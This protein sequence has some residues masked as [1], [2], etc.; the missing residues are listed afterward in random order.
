MK[1]SYPV[2][3]PTT[4]SEN[5]KPA[6]AGMCVHIDVADNGVIVKAFPRQGGMDNEKTYV[7]S[8]IEEALKEVPSIMAV[9]KAQAK[10]N[11]EP[12][13]EPLEEEE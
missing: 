10:D 4:A 13:D 7:F 8:S 9:R 1:D 6:N 11:N 2:T 5:A 12:V 3:T